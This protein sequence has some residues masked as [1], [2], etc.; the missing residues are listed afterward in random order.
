MTRK[1]KKGV[2]VRGRKGGPHFEKESKMAS[3]QIIRRRER[4]RGGRCATGV[5]VGDFY[6]RRKV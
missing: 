1:E 6:V 5:I 3:F 4:K 2:L